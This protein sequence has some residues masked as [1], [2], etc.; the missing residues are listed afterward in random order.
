[1]ELLKFPHTCTALNRPNLTAERTPTN[2]PRSTLVVWS[3]SDWTVLS[4]FNTFNELIRDLI[5]QHTD[6]SA[7]ES[8]SEIR[9]CTLCL[10][11]LLVYLG[12]AL[13]LLMSS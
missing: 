9:I 8:A 13:G 1:M 11:L 3:R 7:L 5:M 4:L 10:H 2:Y 6:W 12:L